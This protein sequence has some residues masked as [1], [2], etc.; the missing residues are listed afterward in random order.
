MKKIMAVDVVQRRLRAACEV[1]ADVLIDGG[2]EDPVKRVKA[3]AGGLGANVSVEMVGKEETVRNAIQ[4]LSPGG[5][6]VVMGICRQGVTAQFFPHDLVLGERQIVGS[7]S[8]SACSWPRS[9][10]SPQ[11]RYP[12][13]S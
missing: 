11:A 12:Q 6:A 13:R 1:G 10:K 4:S 3:E 9:R 5:M 2:L 7:G 8:G